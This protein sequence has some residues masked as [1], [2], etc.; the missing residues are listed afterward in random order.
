M[1]ADDGNCG[2]EPRGDIGS[3]ESVDRSVRMTE[4]P[5]TGDAA[6]AAGDSVWL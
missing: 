5:T 6:A 1:V 4:Y 3:V 2:G